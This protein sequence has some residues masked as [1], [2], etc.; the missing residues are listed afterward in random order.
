M[1]GI[2]GHAVPSGERPD[3][4]AVTAGT[5]QL[6][7]RGPDGEGVMPFETACLGHRR[8]SIIDIA[9]SPQPWSSEDGRY[10]I[11]FNGEIYNYLELRKELA[12]TGFRFRTNGDTEVLLAMYMRH[13]QAC[14]EK[15]NGM[16]AFAVWDD[17]QKELFVARDRVGKKPLFYASFHDGIAFASEIEALRAFKGI[18]RE[19]DPAA[20]HDFFAYQYIPA[21]RTIHRGIRKLP[22]GH[23]LRYRQR[24][25]QIVRY[26]TPPLPSG[27]TCPEQT[28]AEELKALLE[29]AVRLRL[30]SDVPLGAFLSGGLDSSIIVGIM[31]HLGVN[32]DSFHIGF[33]DT[34]YD[35]S[36]HAK[37]AA[38]HFG[39]RHH[40]EILPIEYVMVL[41]RSL[42]HFGEP[43]A[44][45]STIPTWHLC[46]YTREAVTVALSGDGADELFGGY[47]RYY[48][49]RWLDRYRSLPGWLRKHVIERLIRLM[50]EDE[51]YY[52]NSLIKQLKLF[53][54]LSVRTHASP[55]DLLAQTFSLPERRA[56]FKEHISVSSPDHINEFHLENIDGVS[57]MMLADIH[58]YLPDD[59]LVK[60]DRMSMAHALEVRNPFLDHRLVEFSCRLPLTH[61]LQHGQQKYILRTAFR[62][63]LPENVRKREKHGFAVPLGRWFR[64][65][66]ANAFEESVLDATATDFLNRDNILSLWKAHDGGRVDHGFKLWSLFVFHRWYHQVNRP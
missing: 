61:K 51:N 43:F 15:L 50:P 16:F 64:S 32:V 9:G 22:A 59:I 11:I 31:T 18:K 39:T 60:V 66:L 47:R 3:I 54:D 27:N 17:A 10:T 53:S 57:Q 42:R 28:S 56:L 24:Q 63:L 19:L 44:D 30:R 34:S 6:A 35:E 48:A 38:D 26:W 7:H 37:I 36:A 13:G 2:V 52:A 21:P 45:P 58:R 25:T 12:T 46:R 65:T 33:D 49:R 23:F 29:D 41:D 40:S 14:L 5:Q 8:L 62:N 4:A 55:N 20:I 1:C